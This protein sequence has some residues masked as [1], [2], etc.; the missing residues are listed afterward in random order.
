[1][2]REYFHFC[3]CLK[4]DVGLIMLLFI[5]PMKFNII[6]RYLNEQIQNYSCTHKGFRF[7]VTT[8]AML[9]QSSCVLWK[10]YRFLLMKSDKLL[11]CLFVL[12]FISNVIHK[13]TQNKQVMPIQWDNTA[14]LGAVSLW[15][16]E[17]NLRICSTDLRPGVICQNQINID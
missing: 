16:N 12:Y 13:Y 7:H 5:R 8:S 17:D 6:V 2:L 9:W 11:S 15:N 10:P 1:M 14:F 4:K 3:L